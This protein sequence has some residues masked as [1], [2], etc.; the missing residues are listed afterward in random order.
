MKV[1]SKYTIDDCVFIANYTKRKNW[2]RSGGW[3]KFY[4]YYFYLNTFALSAFLIYLN[5]LLAG[6]IVFFINVVI[7]IFLRDKIDKEGYRDHFR[8][9]FIGKD[10]VEFEVKLDENGIS[11]KYDDEID[12]LGTINTFTQWNNVKE[13]VET[14]KT[15]YLFTRRNGIAISKNSFEFEPQMQE[16][17]IF[18]KARVSKAI[19]TI[20]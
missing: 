6:F 3:V 16:F 9:Y 4:S 14:K 17:L 20:N 10:Y 18:A 8:D 13:L 7:L 11:C 15:I 1:I 5:Y 19:S 2:A 12:F